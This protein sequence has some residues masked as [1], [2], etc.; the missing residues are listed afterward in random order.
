MAWDVRI[1]RDDGLPLG[2]AVS[3]KS[4]LASAFPGL[5]FAPD[6]VR[7]TGLAFLAAAPEHLAVD[8]GPFGVLGKVS[9][10]GCTMRFWLGSDDSVAFVDVET[11]GS[12]TFAASRLES[13]SRA[14]G[15]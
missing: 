3:I 15:W 5:E 7:R 14:T 10:K 9:G 13:L 8:D 11:H 12:T 4:R 2:D 1:A 6:P